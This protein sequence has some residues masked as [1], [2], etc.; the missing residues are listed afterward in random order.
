MTLTESFQSKA[1]DIEVVSDER[2]ASF[3]LDCLKR[4][5]CAD[6]IEWSESH[7]AWLI[8]VRPSQRT[9]EQLLKEIGLVK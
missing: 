1:P 2:M 4:G 9:N 7:R 6:M 8:V 5:L 3:H